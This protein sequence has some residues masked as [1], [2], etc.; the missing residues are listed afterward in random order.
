MQRTVFSS[1]HDAARTGQEEDILALVGGSDAEA[2]VNAED[3]FG[4]S[5]LWYACSARPE[6]PGVVAALLKYK[7]D[8]HHCAPAGDLALHAC[9]REHALTVMRM[10]LDAKADVNAC[11]AAEYTP[12]KA[13]IT[14]PVGGLSSVRN[15]EG[16][17][18][19]VRLL[20]ESHADPNSSLSTSLPY[21]EP[22]LFV[23]ARCGRVAVIE[24]LL[25]AKAD[26]CARDRH[27]R[28]ALDQALNRRP[29][30]LDDIAQLLR[31]RSDAE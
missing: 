5:P 30:G 10:L 11:G 22:P 6:K 12:L 14:G 4:A 25:A 17:A 27:G 16:H 29:E 1:L 28:T 31:R 21:D 15:T 18:E 2:A 23:A 13:A 3:D 26:A 8:V 24:T 7:A 19:A 20:C 9:A